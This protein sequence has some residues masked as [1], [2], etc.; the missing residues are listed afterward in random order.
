MN[1]PNHLE[2]II[3]KNAQHTLT[4]MEKIKIITQEFLLSQ[5][6]AQLSPDTYCFDGYESS[7]VFKVFVIADDAVIVVVS[8]TRI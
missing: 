7:Y 2:K 3:E 6:F 1:A 5:G 4:A 8:S